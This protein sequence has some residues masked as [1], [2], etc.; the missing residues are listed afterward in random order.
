MNLMRCEPWDTA[1]TF[2]REIDRLLR[3][4][5]RPFVSQWVPAVD[6]REQEDR[7]LVQLDVP[8]VNP[9]D[10]ELAVENGVLTISG[11]RT[12]EHVEAS[13]GYSRVERQSGKFQRRFTLPDDIDPEAV[14]ARSENGVLEIRIPKSPQTQPRRVEISVN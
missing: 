1:R 8:G 10:I 9:A 12:L 3:N 7:F 13:E 11:S 2:S 4:P 5:D 6:I 14:T